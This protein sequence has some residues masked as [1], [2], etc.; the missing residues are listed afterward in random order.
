M[1]SRSEESLA[2]QPGDSSLRLSMTFPRRC[3]SP[4]NLPVKDKAPLTPTRGVT[5][6]CYPGTQRVVAPLVGAR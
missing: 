6:W 2:Q 5:T 1:L 4:K 3:L